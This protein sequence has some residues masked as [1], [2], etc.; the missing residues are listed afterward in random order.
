MDFPPEEI[1]IV[2]KQD[3]LTEKAVSQINL[4]RWVNATDEVNASPPS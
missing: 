4:T 2:Q 3:N 1:L